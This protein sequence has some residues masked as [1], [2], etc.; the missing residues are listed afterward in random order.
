MF[1]LEFIHLPTKF[2]EGKK[3]LQV[4]I[5]TVII[6]FV[7]PIENSQILIIKLYT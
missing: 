6:P 5:K 7:P 1:L 2:Q 4:I 3:Y